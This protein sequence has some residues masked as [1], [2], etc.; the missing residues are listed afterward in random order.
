[1]PPTTGRRSLSARLIETVKFYG[2]LGFT[3]FGGPSA[4]IV[5]IRKIFVQKEK[6][7][8]DRTFTDLLALGQ[9]LP[10]PAFSQL[11]FSISAL[12]GGIWAAMLS[13]ILLT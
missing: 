8:D 10:G 11:A 6:W 9:A 2:P 4:N 13:F 3:A 12:R 5:L 7:L 1:M